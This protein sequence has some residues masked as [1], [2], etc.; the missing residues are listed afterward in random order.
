[1]SKVKM[2]EMSDDTGHGYGTASPWWAKDEIKVVIFHIW[3]S[4]DVSLLNA[5][6][7]LCHCDSLISNFKSTDDA[8]MPSP[9]VI[10]D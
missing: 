10:G 6:S 9:E 3:I 1:M 5:I 8:D 4:R 2:S 7:L